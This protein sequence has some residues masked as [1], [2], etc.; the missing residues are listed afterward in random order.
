MKDKHYFKY[1]LQAACGS[2]IGVGMAFVPA[3]SW[4]TSIIIFSITRK[5]VKSYFGTMQITT[6][7]KTVL[8]WRDVRIERA[9]GN[10]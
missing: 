2:Q 7:N 4:R 6:I 5:L 3:K 8:K 1:L 10:F 9:H